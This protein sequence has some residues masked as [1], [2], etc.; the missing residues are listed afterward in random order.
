[1][2]SGIFIVEKV[3]FCDLFCG[4]N[5]FEIPAYQRPYAWEKKQWQDLLDDLKNAENSL[6]YLLGTVYLE[7][8]KEN[9]YKILDGQ[10]R[11]VTMYLLMKS[12]GDKNL[13]TIT[14]GGG[15]SEFFEKLS[16]DTEPNKP[17]TA[18]Q[19][20]LKGALKFFTNQKKKF[21][22]KRSQN[23]EHKPEIA[24]QQ[25][26][27]GALK[28]F[29]NQ[30][31]KFFKKRSQNI[32]HK[33]ET[34]SQQRLKGALEF[35]MKQKNES[36]GLLGLIELEKLSIIKTIVDTKEDKNASIT[37]FITQTDRGKR[38]TNLEKLKSILYYYKQKNGDYDLDKI[39]SI[40]SEIYISLNKL[41]TKP[42]AAEADVLRVLMV[43]LEQ[44]QLYRRSDSTNFKELVDEYKNVTEKDYKKVPNV[45]WE[46]GEEE[47]FRWI[48]QV[49]AGCTGDNLNEALSRCVFVLDEIKNTL[50]CYAKNFDNKP[51]ILK[52]IFLSLNPSRFSRAFLVDYLHE[53]EE[54]GIL[55]CI[56]EMQ[57]AIF[58]NAVS[59]PIMPEIPEGVTNYNKLTEYRKAMETRVEKYKELA[60]KDNTIFKLIERIELSC[61]KVGKR[62]IG[63][64]LSYKKE[65]ILD[66]IIRFANNH[67]KEYFL[68]DFGYGNY[69]YILMEYEKYYREQHEC[70]EDF[71]TTMAEGN[72]VTKV[73]REHI[74]AQNP[75]G[76]LWS[77]FLKKGFGDNK[78][79]YQSWIWNI[80]NIALLT[81]GKNISA[82]N[83]TPWNKA[84]EYEEQTDFETTKQLGK[85]ILEYCKDENLNTLKTMLDIREYEL[86]AFA[87]Y[88]F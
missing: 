40:F 15:D 7:K 60:N 76:E 53:C 24:S 38:L 34:A 83:K 48:Q 2:S 39:Q 50:A 49:F 56:E 29:T 81:E 25:K 26:L 82:G 59:K 31:K 18:S 78:T 33:P 86:K 47:I 32:E 55:D 77:E 41:Y 42:E 16:K 88:R 10:Q 19:Q 58:E 22:K 44:E 62:P 75:E 61:W 8:T 45:S 21:F 28:F 64:F 68:R 13:P 6:E 54:K 79:S 87:W 67:K 1:M 27:K 69:R 23:I 20:R 3:K 66:H 65:H 72:E 30:K 5:S 70:M 63:T 57:N 51:P 52:N 43:R 80:G 11:F 36:N 46:A 14:L 12:L 85:D 71:Y 35:F 74:F 37:T 9:E 84:K 17:E 73:H 4:R